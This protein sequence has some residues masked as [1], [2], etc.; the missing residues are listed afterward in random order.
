MF[1][2]SSSSTSTEASSSAAPRDYTDVL[3]ETIQQRSEQVRDATKAKAAA[4]FGQLV[5]FI[6]P[7][8]LAFPKEFTFQPTHTAES[9]RVLVPLI[10]SSNTTIPFKFDNGDTIATV[11][12]FNEF[13]TE[14]VATFKDVPGFSAE[15]SNIQIT[16]DQ[17]PEGS[18][19]SEPI[20]VLVISVT[21]QKHGAP[22]SKDDDPHQNIRG[23]VF[24]Q[25]QD[26]KNILNSEIEKT[27]AQLYQNLLNGI[28][29][30]VIA[31]PE[32]VREFFSED[33]KNWYYA[34]KIGRSKR[35]DGTDTFSFKLNTPTGEL[36][37]NID[38]YDK[39][40]EETRARLSL[41]KG[42][43]AEV[44]DYAPE[45]S[46]ESIPVIALTLSKN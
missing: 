9:V 39:L 34:H 6:L 43:V 23:F 3:K 4:Y 24:Y 35:E 40:I 30:I 7:A 16:P 13:C 22:H 38:I 5:N 20:T 1:P 14:L 27:A 46:S 31:Y 44:R 2:S 36:I 25:E 37:A 12:V 18:N 17:L 42:I 21:I 33:E 10:R 29:P 11:D 19:I 32:T 15:L 26:M 8:N 28:I 41:V 45:G